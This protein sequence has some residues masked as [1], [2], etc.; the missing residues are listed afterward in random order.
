[1]KWRR[2]EVCRKR[3]AI[4]RKGETGSGRKIK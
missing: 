2:V 4:K 1:M 3:L